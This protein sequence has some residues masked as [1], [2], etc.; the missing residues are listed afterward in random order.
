MRK[1][2]D[3]IL[4]GL[5]GCFVG[6]TYFLIEVAWKTARGH[7]QGISWTMITSIMQRNQN[8]NYAAKKDISHW[9]PNWT[10]GESPES[11]ALRGLLLTKI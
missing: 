11:I 6:V 3:V 7:P 8:S 5:L 1:S 9:C 10:Q 2:G 4:S